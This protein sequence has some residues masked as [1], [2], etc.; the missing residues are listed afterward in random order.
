MLDAAER[1]GASGFASDFGRGSS[2]QDAC[3]PTAGGEL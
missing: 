1:P 2:I 3:V